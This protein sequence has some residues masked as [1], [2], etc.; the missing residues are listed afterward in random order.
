M[1]STYDH[2]VIQG[3]ES[4]AFL[5][6]I[7]QLL[8]GEDGF[9]DSVFGAMGVEA[10]AEAPSVTAAEPVPAATT[11]ARRARRGRRAPP[12]GAGRHLAGQGPPHARPPGRPARPARIRAG[13]RPGARAGDGR[14]GRR[15]DAAHPGVGAARGGAGRHLR[16]RAPAAAQDLHGH[17]RLRDR[18]HLRPPA[19]HL[20][21][22]GH[23]VGHLPAAH[24]LG[25]PLQAARA[26]GRG[27]GARELPP[28]GL[29]GQEAVLDR[30]PRRGRADARRVDRARRGGRGARGGA[31]HGT[32]RPA[33]RAR[34]HGRP[35]VRRDPRR[36]RGRADDRRRDGRARGRHRRR[37]VP[38][39]RQRH[40]LRRTRAGA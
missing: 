25:G 32:P 13:G 31:R 23:R 7:D 1:T 15:A 37:E 19:A 12:G 33:E 28:Q 10:P 22:P 9:Y 36:V 35:P 18:A 11:P 14:P 21:A 38:L 4:G 2:R 29:P 5:R 20:A 30:G 39:R 27:G 17:D 8:Q 40:L 3:A 26:A 34:P 6:R 16:R 24:E